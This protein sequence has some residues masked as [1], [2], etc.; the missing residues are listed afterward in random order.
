MLHSGPG[1]VGGSVGK[2]GSG[3]GKDSRMGGPAQGWGW[4]QLPALRP[5]PNSAPDSTSGV[6]PS[7]PIG[8][9]A[10]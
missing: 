6:D 1:K 8:I 10:V 9:A 3:Q 4:D 5:D 7:S 2:A